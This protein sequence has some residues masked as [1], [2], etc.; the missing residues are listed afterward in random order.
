MMKLI[1]STLFLAIVLIIL[2]PADLRSQSKAPPAPPLKL[3]IIKDD[4]QFDGC[5]CSLYLNRGDERN[6]RAVFLADF[7]ENAAINLNG[8]DLKLRLTDSSPEKNDNAK[9]GDR[10]WEIYKAGSTTLRVDY[11]ITK[12]CDPNDESC[13][14]IHYR[15]TLTLIQKGQ[16]TSIRTTGLC[17]C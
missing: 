5:G 17:G 3:G 8:K 13:E 11:T 4:R 15:A 2:M 14:V 6:H 10:S 16:K 1:V 9:V 12:V 7:S